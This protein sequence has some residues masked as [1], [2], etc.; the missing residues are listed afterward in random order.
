MMRS[1]HDYWMLD[2]CQPRVWHGRLQQHFVV[3]FQLCDLKTLKVNLN[4][5]SGI[6]PANQ[7]DDS[8][9]YGV[10]LCYNLLV[11]AMYYRSGTV[12]LK[13]FVGKVFL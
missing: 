4:S 5:K 1:V 9:E 13:S 8:I 10:V 11:G 2:G 12:N 6:V 7:Y 3:I